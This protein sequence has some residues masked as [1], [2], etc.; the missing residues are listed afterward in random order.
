MSTGIC[1]NA[2]VEL[3]SKFDTNSPYHDKIF[4]EY[5]DPAD[6]VALEIETVVQNSIVAL[7]V[8]ST[9]PPASVIIT[10][11]AG[12]GKTRIC[13]AVIEAL[14]VKVPSWSSRISIR[15]GSGHE[16]V[17]LKDLSE[18]SDGDAQR[19]L[20]LL[21]EELAK[22]LNERKVRFLIAANEGKLTH[23]LVTASLGDLKAQIRGQI[24]K[25]DLLNKELQ[26]YN[27]MRITS[28]SYV[29][30][31]L[32]KITAEENW[33]P[34][35]TCQVSKSCVIKYN[36][37]TLRRAPV[38]DQLTWLYRNLDQVNVHLTLRDTLIHLAHVVTGGLNC[39]D[40][41]EL[42][43]RNDAFPLARRAYYDNVWAENIGVENRKKFTAVQALNRFK[44][45]DYSRFEID[46]FIV[47]G[48]LHRKGE[49]RE[50]H[51]KFFDH[52][53]DLA[54]PKFDLERK[55]FIWGR[56]A[57]ANELALKN[58][59]FVKFW[60]P[61]C[62]RKV[63]FE[64]DTLGFERTYLLPYQGISR[65]WKVVDNHGSL[66]SKRTKKRIVAGLNRAFTGMYLEFDAK[67]PE[68]LWITSN[69]VTSRL[70]S[71]PIVRGRFYEGL[72]K[73]I[74][75]ESRPVTVNLDREIRELF[76]KIGD[77]K[78]PVDLL[79]FEYLLGLSAGS[80]PQAMAAECEL[81]L[82]ELK[83]MLLQRSVEISEDSIDFVALKDGR[84]QVV[85]IALSEMGGASC[86]TMQN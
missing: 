27:L 1:S 5:A 48:D 70:R 45:G 66:E 31:L 60:L 84:Y 74:V 36:A 18:L 55:R 40:V 12:D 72:I 83:D 56:Y 79:T 2:F 25:P 52:A 85:T 28:S 13:R 47:D 62:R 29:R 30:K 53:P 3:L 65:F 69:Y 17:V 9:A 86:L 39:A 19:E 68:E 32:A 81:R 67:A 80:V 34:C 44:V 42:V 35:S 16:L 50:A 41:F 24:K 8:N 58:E 71:A 37:T 15:A 7:M 6:A 63:F 76:L 64:G 22:P 20:A 61:H 4:D 49:L 54:G 23:N 77:Y 14:G 78:F 11:N 82:K 46:E 10:G 21:G 26:V 33:S 73:W 51:L 38:Q 57:D 75:E 59:D 43:S